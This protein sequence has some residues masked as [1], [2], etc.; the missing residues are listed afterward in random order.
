M[1]LSAAEQTQIKAL[2]AREGG[3]AAFTSE[4][5]AVNVA[6]T[7]AAALTALGPAVSVTVTDWAAVASFIA[8][9]SN[10]TLYS[11]MAAIKASAAARD[12]SQM[13]PLLVAL[14]GA[15]KAHLSL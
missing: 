1:A 4:V 13:G 15:V 7:Q 12:A 8:A 3:I 10:V 14:Y 9:S 2:I 11:V 6:N 5:Q